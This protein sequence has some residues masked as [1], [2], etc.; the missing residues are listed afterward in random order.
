MW[1]VIIAYIAWCIVLYLLQDRMLFPAD[2]AGE[3]LAGPPDADTVVMTLA[4][5]GGG[6]VE[7]WFF[8]ARSGTP[9]RPHT[10]VVFFH[11]NAE[12]V[13]YQDPI[14][15]AYR[16]V[17]CSVLLPEYRGYGR[18]AGKP[19]QDAIV[20]DAIHFYDELVKRNDVDKSRIVFHGRSLGAGV[21]AAV[22]V[23]RT[24]GA[25]I[26]ESAFSS[27][28]AMSRKYLV[29]TFLAKH[30][31]R[32]DRFVAGAEMPIL[33]FH[34]RNDGIVPVSHGRKLRDLARNGQYVEYECG[35]NDFPGDG[36]LDNYWA[37]IEEFLSGADI[38]RHVNDE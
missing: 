24:P 26:I 25:L 27:V 19:S 4:L 21:A 15:S 14:V 11:G 9:D 7:S 1:Y 18:S 10:V 38:L 13:D 2:M 36:N 23:H 31:F 6:R 16:R 30:P 35:H 37:T 20:A 33:I 32:T 8:P 3:P 5:N 22:A 28:A 17:G 34:G 29:P 12:L